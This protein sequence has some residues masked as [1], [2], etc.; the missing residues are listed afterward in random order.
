IQQ[1]Q[2]RQEHNFFG[3]SDG[4]IENILQRSGAFE[5]SVNAR[6]VCKEWRKICQDPAM[7]RVINMEDP[8]SKFWKYPKQLKKMCRQA[9]DW[10]QGQLVDIKIERIASIG[11]IEYLSANKRCNSAQ[12]S[13]NFKEH[14]Q[15][16]LSLGVLYSRSLLHWR[17]FLLSLLSLKK[18]TVKN[19]GQYCL[20]LKS[21]KYHEPIYHLTRAYHPSKSTHDEEDFVLTVTK[22]MPQLRHLEL[23]GIE[24]TNMGLH[25]IL[26]G[27]P[28][29]VSLDLRRCFY[30]NLD[31][32]CGMLCK[33]CI[34]DLRLPDK[35]HQI[36]FNAFMLCGQRMIFIVM[37]VMAGHMFDIYSYNDP[38]TLAVFTALSF[39]PEVR[40][41]HSKVKF[42]V[43][44]H[45]QVPA[46]RSGLIPNYSFGFDNLNVPLY[47]CV[48]VHPADALRLARQRAQDFADYLCKK[49][50]TR[51]VKNTHLSD[52]PDDIIENILQRIGAF[53]ILV[54][55]QRAIDRSQG[56][57]VHIKIEHIA[58]DELL[59]YL[60]ANKR[61]SQLRRLQILCHYCWK[62]NSCSNL[63]QK[64][65]LLEE[66]SIT[67][68]VDRKKIVSNAG[69]YCLRLESFKYHQTNCRTDFNGPSGITRD[70]DDFVIAITKA[71]P[72]LRHLELVGCEMT[73]TG[74]QA[75][76]DGCPHLVSLD[77]R[78]CFNINLNSSCGMLCKER[79]KVLRLP[80]DR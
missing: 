27:S 34:K 23:V 32:S 17:K 36:F 35:K 67:F 33:E 11:L 48:P 51:E 65:P 38:T 24:M 6:R 68:S 58:T 56:Q 3:S 73:N 66:I 31:S 70:E 43:S 30:I 14:Y 16:R 50:G 40:R 20:Q 55:A 9:I 54:N 22:A 18:V 72:Q 8:G 52:L 13:S 46:L 4:I 60:A 79:I 77:L 41:R 53:E 49:Y 78:R 80:Y 29:L 28:H 69:Q 1:K 10:S 5:I 44:Y 21:F 75:I 47:N 39:P 61:S 37:N 63:F 2:C 45:D 71:M 7:W 59:D 76:L 74:L 25:A 26:D 15:Q 64:S 57:L 12:T 19:A 62:V 42:A